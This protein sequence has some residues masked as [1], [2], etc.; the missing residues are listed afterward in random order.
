MNLDSFP[1]WAS[2]TTE[3]QRH[4]CNDCRQAKLFNRWQRQPNSDIVRKGVRYILIRHISNWYIDN[5]RKYQY[6]LRKFS[7]KNIDI[8]IDKEVEISK[9]TLKK[10]VK[11]DN[12]HIFLV[13][14]RMKL[15]RYPWRS[16]RRRSGFIFSGKLS[17]LAGA[18]VCLSG[19][20][21]FA[22][23]FFLCW[24]ILSLATCLQ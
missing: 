17:G 23:T 11:N 5:F 9:T 12:K 3:R 24:T 2:S 14:H 7:L 6:L 10:G 4:M 20:Q 15:I 8:N 21:L 16:R 19:D 13:H 1:N 18:V 22:T